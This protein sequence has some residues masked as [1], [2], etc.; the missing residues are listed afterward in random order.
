MRIYLI[1]FMGA[2]KTRLGKKLSKLMNYPF[3][4]L[5]DLIIQESGCSIKE[6]FEQFGEKYFRKLEQ[7]VL[8][9][10]LKYE[11]AIISTGG[12]APCFFDNIEWIKN[13]GTSIYLDVE[14]NILV[15]R[16]WRGREKRPLLN[17]LQKSELLPFIK[18]KIDEREKY[19]LQASIHY[20]IQIEDQN[21]AEEL[22]AYLNPIGK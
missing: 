8:H 20:K 2:G 13:N 18:S 17:G 19:Y 6:V 22:S 10:T 4:D 9:Q 5:D 11:N 21:S 12:G 15:D 1:G 14:K 16:L 7:K 3:Y